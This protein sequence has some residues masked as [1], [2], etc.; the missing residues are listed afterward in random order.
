MRQELQPMRAV[1]D[2][3]MA[4]AQQEQDPLLL[5]EAHLLVGVSRAWV[6]ELPS[7]LGHYD[8]AREH[9]GAVSPGHVDF[10]VGANP[11]VVA[12]VAAGLTQY[13]AGSPDTAMRDM[14]QALDLAA[15][16][17]HPYSMAYAVHHAALLD[18]WRMDLAGVAARADA[19]LAITEVHDFPTWRALAY[20]WQGLAMVGTG[21][22]D[23][24][25]GVARIEEGFD[26]YQGLSAPPVFMPGLLMV[27]ASALGM[28]RR[29]EEGLHVIQDAKDALEEGDPL[30]ADVDIVRGE[31]L[32]RTAAPD[33]AA[34]E[35]LFE[36]AAAEA[37]ER[38]A[39]MPQLRALT[40]LAELRTGTPA[41]TDTLR[42][43][44]ALCDGFTEGRDDPVDPHLLA[45]RAILDADPPG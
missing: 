33:V 14:Q 4:I 6:D 9:L 41:A 39:R 3:L 22:G 15:S 7:S 8:A 32:L 17:D 1:A 43:L 45:A 12:N 11:G 35:A 34:A 20:V 16:L 19:L 13:M 29:P 28:A 31:L 42:A 10:R 18:V 36:R 23:P 44:R 27:R 21:P 24:E 25:A 38:R 5:S 37:G 26:L 40:H 30:S 2:E